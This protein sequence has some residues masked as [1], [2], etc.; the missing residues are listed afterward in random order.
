MPTDRLGFVVMVDKIG[1]E[2]LQE[3][4]EVSAM[5]KLL[6]V[7][8]LGAS[9]AFASGAAFAE[10]RGVVEPVSQPTQPATVSVY[11]DSNPGTFAGGPAH[12]VSVD[13][14]RGQEGNNR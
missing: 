11:F 9:L 8:V 4:N 5:Q 12:D 10:D 2:A 1:A 13:A 3:S 6:A 7:A 14:S